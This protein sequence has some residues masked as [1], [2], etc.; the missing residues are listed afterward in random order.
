MT[1][2]LERTDIG[3]SMGIRDGKA[4]QKK[5]KKKQGRGTTNPER[6]GIGMSMGIGDGKPAPILLKADK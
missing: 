2:N 6:T 3:M 4:D 5:K 1:T